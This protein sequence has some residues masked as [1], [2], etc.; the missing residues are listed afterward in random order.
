MDWSWL[1]SLLA[2]SKKKEQK[3]VKVDQS[4]K[5]VDYTPTRASMGGGY[6][7]PDEPAYTAPGTTELSLSNI[8]TSS[9]DLYTTGYDRPKEGAKTKT[10]EG[11]GQL[12][13]GL[14]N[15]GEKSNSNLNSVRVGQSMKLVEPKTIS[16]DEVA[17]KRASSFGD[18]RYK[19]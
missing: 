17:R 14:L 11:W 19:I 16:L 6:I 7:S 13:A 10:D 4:L 12:I 3:P 18:F 5:L 15:S 8:P 1:I 9:E 2:S